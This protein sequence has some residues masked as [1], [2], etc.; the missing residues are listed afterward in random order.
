VFSTISR[1]VGGAWPLG[2]RALDGRGDL[3]W[4][5]VAATADDRE[6]NARQR[7]AAAA[8]VEHA[9][10]ALTG[11]DVVP[12]AAVREHRDQVAHG[13]ARHEEGGLQAG[14]LRGAG[15]QGVHRGVVTEDVVP[16]DR[17]GHGPAH[18]CRGARDGV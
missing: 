3:V 7:R 4:R 6:L 15:L 14:Q 17:L 13:A 2:V 11:E 1:R 10:R 8:L 5:E 18:A 12:G 16:H 9:V